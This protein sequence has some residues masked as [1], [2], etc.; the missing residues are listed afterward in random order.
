M[1]MTTSHWIML[2]LFL[3]NPA[4]AEKIV[5][6]FTGVNEYMAAFV[7]ADQKMFEKRGLDVSLQLLPNGGV[8][9]PGLVSG[10][11]QVGGITIP[12]LLQ[13][14]AGGLDLGIIAN[15]SVIQQSNPDGSVV[16][17]TGADI[18]APAD[19]IGRRVAVSAV[20]SLYHVL[21]RQY[22][23]D[24]GVDPGRVNFVEISF[25]QMGD[26]LKGGQVDAAT[27]TEPFI[28][29]FKAAGIAYEVAP[30]TAHFPNG[31]VSNLY[32]ATKG[33]A[34]GHVAEV[35]ALR[36][37]LSEAVDYIP[38]HRAESE[39]AEAHYLK[40]SPETVKSLPFSNYTSV[41]TAAQIQAWNKIAR[42]QNL[43][44][45]DVSPASVLLP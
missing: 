24:E 43:I 30:F 25:G 38:G 18:H 33:W 31:T 16:A 20:G 5:L 15:G 13:A 17:R 2:S 9:P 44:D 19:F 22:L 23:Q 21:F 41:I 37:A 35:A 12:L 11:L 32:V 7:A 39:A 3:A 40:L 45:T 6:G 14:A 8:I 1:K 36:A 29:R 10:S 42:A 27:T 28:G 26:V 34:A 4:H